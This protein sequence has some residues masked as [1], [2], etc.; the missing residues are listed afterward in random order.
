MT[1]STSVRPA[2]SSALDQP[3]YDANGHASFAICACCGTE[4]GYDDASRSHAE[5]RS[6]WIEAGMKWWS[7]REPPPGWDPSLQ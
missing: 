5:R 2:D 3:A 7:K 1:T 4:F 6:Q